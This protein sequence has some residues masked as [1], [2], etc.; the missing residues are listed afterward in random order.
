MFENVFSFNRGSQINQNCD[1]L[2]NVFV[3]DFKNKDFKGAFLPWKL[4]FKNCPD[5]SIL[6]YRYGI[7]I[8]QNRYDHAVTIEEKDRVSQLMD[9][10]YQ[11]RIR[12]FPQNIGKVYNS[13]A[14]NL[15]E[16]GAS[17]E[18][19]F[20]K[21]DMAYKSN[22]ESLSIKNTALFF[23][24]I[25]EK[26]WHNNKQKVLNVYDTLLLVNKTEIIRYNKLLDSLNNEDDLTEKGLLQKKNYTILLRSLGQIE[27][28]LNSL[29]P[30]ESTSCTELL[31][32]YQNYY[33]K[34]ENNAKWL[35]PA[36]SR[37]LRRGCTETELY[38][39]MVASWEK[40]SVNYLPSIVFK[41]SLGNKIDYNSLEELNDLIGTL[42]DNYKKAE[43][44]L[45]IAFLYRHSNKPKARV[46]AHKAIDASPN[47]GEAYILIANLYASSANSCGADEFS[48]RMVYLAAADKV[49][50]AIEVDPSISS[51]GN[52]MLKAY[53]E[54]APYAQLKF[55][56]KKE[57][58]INCWINETV[59]IP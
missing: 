10:V 45:R 28:F 22:P 27:G 30:P 24:Q 4:T 44:Y 6:T 2:Y 23:D 57:F 3:Q 12:Y 1:S 56:N 59:I 53:L 15:Q 11:Q 18:V 52:R 33:R 51:K 19:V 47:M 34:N 13:W 20:E 5:K 36:V 31:S 35:K 8:L 7:I 50:K 42:N 40:L 37:L 46:Y 54:N 48:K 21:L 26:H 39:D 55:Y 43:Y 49:R 9:S 32:L 16:M 38:Q 25:N 17:K 14:N 29:M 58:K 41:D